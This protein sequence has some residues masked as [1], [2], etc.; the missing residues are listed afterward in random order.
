MFIRF[1]TLKIDE[2]SHQSQGLFQAAYSLLNA[3][4]LNAGEREEVQM[5]IDW[6]K[7]NLPYPDQPDVEGR[8]VFWYLDS[9]HTHIKKMWNLANIL[10]S[11]NCAVE[12]QKC[13]YLGNIVYQDEHQVAAYPHRRDAGVT[14]N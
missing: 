10:R 1:V 11:H 6:F 13:R 2:D 9:A 5:L 8:A 7:D 12:I 14:T 3:G 4:D